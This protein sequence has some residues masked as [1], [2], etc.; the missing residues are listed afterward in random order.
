MQ[1]LSP[2]SWLVVLATILIGGLVASTILVERRAGRLDERAAD[3]VDNAA[4]SIT[5]LAAARSET[6]RLELG[7][8]RYLGAHIGGIAYHRPQ[9]EQWKRAIDVHLDDHARTPYFDGERE[10]TEALQVAKNRLYA[11]VD[12]VL[13]AIDGRRFD[14][15]RSLI[16]G[17]LSRDGD[18]VDRLISQLI[19]V[20]NENAAIAAADM[21]VLRRRTTTLSVLLDASSVLL[22]AVLLLA[23]VRAARL[24]RRALDERHLAEQRAR[25]LDQFAARVAHDLKGPL[26][27]VVLGTSVAAQHPSE[28][29][30]VLER[31]QR[32]SRLMSQMIDALLAVA[33]VDPKAAP[34]RE[35]ASVAPVVSVLVE[36]LRPVADAARATVRIEACPPQAAVACSAGVLASVLSN[37]LQNAIKHIGE[38]HGERTVSVTIRE[39]DH[40]FHFEVRD[41]GPGVPAHISDRVFERYVRG[42]RSSGLGLGLA[43]VKHLVEG[44]GGRLGF[45]SAAGKGSCFWFDLPRAVSN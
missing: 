12:R 41:T 20:N 27:S 19:L 8:G 36:E 24:Y 5:A 37:L 7:V 15:A 38:S 14:E 16:L 29:R 1:R 13:D 40:G 30:A 35:S 18:A 9:V 22:G 3:I 10:A 11:D 23:A 33:R 4:P 25:E 34:A 17:E 28:T 31:V 21:T 43:T 32:T 6:R 44:A 26:A 2:V 39:R 42:E 45:E